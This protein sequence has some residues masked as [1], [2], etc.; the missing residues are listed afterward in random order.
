MDNKLP[1]GVARQPS[2]RPSTRERA[3]QPVGQPSIELRTAE[4]NLHT[5]A[6]A[7][8][9]SAPAFVLDAVR[10]GHVQVAPLESTDPEPPEP[11]EQRSA[12]HD[13]VAQVPTGRLL[14]HWPMRVRVDGG[15]GT[16]QLLTVHAP[17]TQTDYRADPHDLDAARDYFTQ[18]TGRAVEAISPSTAHRPEASQRAIGTLRVHVPRFMLSPSRVDRA[19]SRKLAL[20]QR[21]FGV[22]MELAAAFG[23]DQTALRTLLRSPAAVRKLYRVLGGDAPACVWDASLGVPLRLSRGGVRV[24]GAVLD[25]ARTVGELAIELGHAP[26]AHAALARL[27]CDLA[28]TALADVAP[29]Q[30][31]ERLAQAGAALGLDDK[32]VA[33]AHSDALSWVDAL[34]ALP[35]SGSARLAWA[36]LRRLLDGGD[37]V[38]VP[39]PAGKPRH[40]QCL[41]L[42]YKKAALGVAPDTAREALHLMKSLQGGAH[43][44]GCVRECESIP[45]HDT[46]GPTGSPRQGK[47]DGTAVAGIAL[48]AQELDPVEI[49]PEATTGMSF[50]GLLALAVTRAQEGPQQA[51]KAL[52]LLFH[53][54]DE[55]PDA[56]T[57]QQHRRA[58]GLALATV[59]RHL[60]AYGLTAQAD[61]EYLLV[62]EKLIQIWRCSDVLAAATLD[63]MRPRDVLA[64][65]WRV[66][67]LAAGLPGVQPATADVCTFVDRHSKAALQDLLGIVDGLEC[68]EKT[69]LAC[70]RRIQQSFSVSAVHQGARAAA[71]LTP[72]Q[73]LDLLDWIGQQLPVLLRDPSTANSVGEMAALLVAL[74][75]RHDAQDM[76]DEGA[77]VMAACRTQLAAISAAPGVRRLLSL[78]NQFDTLKR[79]RPPKGRLRPDEALTD[80]AE[81]LDK[82]PHANPASALVFQQV[83]GAWVQA[84]LKA[85]FVSEQ[86]TLT[87]L[88][89]LGPIVADDIEFRHLAAHQWPLQFAFVSWQKALKPLLEKE[90]GQFYSTTVP[91]ML[92]WAGFDARQQLGVAVVADLIADFVIESGADHLLSAVVMAQPTL[93]NEQRLLWN[94][95]HVRVL[96]RLLMSCI[97]REHNRVAKGIV[98]RLL[99][100]V[101]RADPGLVADA[102]DDVLQALTHVRWQQNDEVAELRE[103]VKVAKTMHGSQEARQ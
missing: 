84:A 92:R 22:V 28:L 82:Q 77:G 34:L 85:P 54:P 2:P 57:W 15:D 49:A 44:M 101:G 61:K 11:T 32:A 62:C 70:L 18:W 96:L 41:V 76:S 45:L 31:L 46:S 53:A 40:L 59:L 56:A 99:H 75:I 36:V 58:A 73:S 6:L 50:D 102:F 19:S 81:E 42:L 63:R 52:A 55:A 25:A 38:D 60:Q 29:L 68:D 33:H 80:I 87:E 86:G 74:A 4:G 5:V 23:L 89:W 72:T 3:G 51:L 10:Q 64:R 1:V 20:A 103:R 13:D 98:L 12:P 21:A 91:E 35:G 30:L 88:Q 93:T 37:R 7:T 8:Q 16:H 48:T 79:L 78:L 65:L 9:G 66:A 100:G 83:L 97:E 71:R 27:A 14:G 94:S 67:W 47:T 24:H 90:L 69:T 95:C 26:A 43:L 39:A 17:H